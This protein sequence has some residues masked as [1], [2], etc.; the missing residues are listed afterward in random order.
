MLRVFTANRP[1]TNQEHH[2]P[3]ARYVDIPLSGSGKFVQIHI[4]RA[5]GNSW[6]LISEVVFEGRI[7]R[8]QAP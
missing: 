7:S 1:F 8:D 6:T 3:K 4:V 5:D 2:D